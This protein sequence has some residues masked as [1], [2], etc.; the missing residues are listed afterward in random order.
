MAKYQLSD[1][2]RGQRTLANGAIAGFIDSGKRDENDEMIQIPTQIYDDVN[3]VLQADGWKL[4]Y[5]K[6]DNYRTNIKIDWNMPNDNQDMFRVLS[7]NNKFRK[8]KTKYNIGDYIYIYD[9]FTGKSI[10]SMGDDGRLD[11]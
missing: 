10:G 11:I 4:S 1:I 5:E 6:L 9:G 8:L 3:Y 2:V 7:L